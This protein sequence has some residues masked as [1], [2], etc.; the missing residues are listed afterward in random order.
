ME[1]LSM[2]PIIKSK[3]SKRIPKI[4]IIL[5]CHN[6]EQAIGLCLKKIKTILAKNQIIGEIIVSDSSTDQ[7]A[8]IATGL[9]DKIVQHQKIGYGLAYREAFPHASGDY[10]FMADP[11]G[12]YDFAEIPNFM[13]QL[14]NGNDLVIGNRL[15]GKIYPGAM[16]W[17]HR[18]LGT[19][20]LSFIFRQIFDITIN[21]INCGMR[22]I[23][24]EKLALL[25]FRTEGMEFASEMLVEASKKKLK[26]SQVS[27]NYHPRL[28][29]SKLKAYR[30]AKRH[31]L[32]M[33]QAS[34]KNYA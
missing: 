28:G 34:R 1:I 31:L 6:E 15:A 25:N 29:N 14:N 8:K 22:A 10:I 16:P 17:I 19:P 33:W 9:A 27:I 11:D 13:T 30:D 12:S 20:L 3:S 4:S 7:S 2:M 5:P 32:F 21:D 26:I 24:R 18:Y 23:R